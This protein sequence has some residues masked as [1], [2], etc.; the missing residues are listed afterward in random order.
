MDG[1]RAMREKAIYRVEGESKQ[2][3]FICKSHN[4]F[5]ALIASS[6][7]IITSLNENYISRLFIIII[8]V[9]LI[10]SLKMDTKV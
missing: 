8:V 3:M 9:V 1:T 4:P 7:A 10:C 5:I 6:N 2:P